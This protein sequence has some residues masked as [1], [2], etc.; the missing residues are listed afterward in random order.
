MHSAAASVFLKEKEAVFYVL[1]KPNS[2]INFSCFSSLPT[3]PLLISAESRRLI[4]PAASVRMLEL[5]FGAQAV[6]VGT[7][8]FMSEIGLNSSSLTAFSGVKSWL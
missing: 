3:E 5:R 2:V 1:Q 4:P 7:Y 8:G 6:P